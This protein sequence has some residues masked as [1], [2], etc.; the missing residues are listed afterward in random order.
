MFNKSRTSERLVLE[1]LLLFLLPDQQV[2]ILVLTLG[3]VIRTVVATV[4]QIS[5]SCSSSDPN[6]EMM[7]VI[8]APPLKQSLL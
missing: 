5:S 3:P 4:C 1:L 6:S 2:L 7:D 8:F